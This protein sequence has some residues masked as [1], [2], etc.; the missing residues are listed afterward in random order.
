[1]VNQAI[2]IGIAVGVFFAGLGIGYAAFSSTPTMPMMMG[3]RYSM[4]NQLISDPQAMTEFMNQIMGQMMMNPQAVQLMHQMMFNDT[5]H[6]Q[7][8]AKNMTGMGN[9]HMGR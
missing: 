8:M 1:M 6:M 3:Q 7:Q 4:M 2:W 5:Q 9:M